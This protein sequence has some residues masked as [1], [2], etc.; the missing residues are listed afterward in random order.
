VGAVAGK[1]L[2]IEPVEVPEEGCEVL[3]GVGSVVGHVGYCPVANLTPR[4]TKIPGGRPLGRV[5][6]MDID[7]P[8]LD[9]DC[10]DNLQY[11]SLLRVARNNYV[12]VLDLLIPRLL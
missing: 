4:P 3:P 7:P 1:S 6:V 10:Y 9:P 8:S 5:S 2:V 11:A 12:A